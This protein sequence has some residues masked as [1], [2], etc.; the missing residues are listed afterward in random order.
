MLPCSRMHV[1]LPGWIVFAVACAG[2][3]V[4]RADDEADLQAAVAEGIACHERADYPAATKAY[5][6]ALALAPKVYGAEHEETALI[7]NNLGILY[8]SLGRY[9]QAEALYQKGLAIR[10]AK[11]GPDHLDVA[12]SLNN[13][14]SLYC[15]T[16]RYTEA[17]TVGQRSL[18]IR[19]SQLEADDPLLA[20]SLVN[21]ASVYTNLYENDKAET[22][23]LRGLKISEAKLGPDHPDVASN[24]N[25]LAALY[26]NL[27]RF[28]EAEPL[29]LRSLKIRETK[30]GA[31][32][33]EVAGSLNNLGG[34]YLA[35]GQYAKAQPL[36]RRGLEISVAR[37]G[38]QHPN[39][40]MMMN[41][42][43]VLWKEMGE[44]AKAEPVY[45]A[46]L[47]MREFSLGRNHPDVATTLSNLA[48]LYTHMDQYA[49]AEPLMLR[50]LE[51]RESKLGADHPDVAASLNNLATLYFEMREYSKA[52]APYRRSFEILKSKLGAEHPL[53]AFSLNSVALLH[54]AQ[55]QW[56]QAAGEIERERRIIRRHI[57]RT[58]PA[59]SEREQLA[60]LQTQNERAFFMA[61]SLG[62]QRREDHAIARASAGWVLNGKAVAQEVLAQRALAAADAKDPDTADLAQRAAS[63]R[64]RLAALGMSLPKSGQEAAYRQQLQSLSREEAELSRQLGAATGRKTANRSWVELDTLRKALAKDAILIEM[65][66]F[67]LAG[68]HDGRWQPAHY[69]AWVIPAEGNGEVA[70]VDLGEAKTIDA[71]VQRTRKALEAADENIRRDGES[72]AEEQ[73]R[74]TLRKL[75][76]LVLDPLDEHLGPARQWIL[77]PDAALWLIPWAA[78]PRSDGQYALE[79]HTIR[80]LV[81]GR[82][83]VEAAPAKESSLTAP[84]IFANPDYDLGTEQAAAAYHAV[85]RD[86]T[87]ARPTVV[88][89]GARSQGSLPRVA[90]LPGTADEAKAI[91]NSLARYASMETVVYEDQYALEGVF[92]SL[93]RPRALVLSTHG[94]FLPDQQVQSREDRL[95]KVAG[96]GDGKEAPVLTSEGRPLE[97]PLLRCGLLLTG[98][99][100]RTADESPSGDDGVLT[101]MEIVGTDL[102]DT[103]LVVLSACDTGLGQVHNGEG[104]AG[105]RQAFGLAGARSVVS[106][107]WQIP[108]QETVQLMDAFFANLAGGQPK[109]EAL[110]NAQL[111]QIRNLRDSRSAAHPYYWAAFTL[112]G[113]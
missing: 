94:F 15:A 55:E 39:V 34:L 96:D 89:R 27:G 56:S 30:L 108:D 51:I 71:A 12:D 69:A 85:F 33:P 32:H 54:A 10:E 7:T 3:G 88:S 46:A 68:F 22:L 113:E 45:Q 106:T 43:A 19:E 58:L 24:L 11:F 16:G 57:T 84:A 102:R 104:V 64:N 52:E 14:I 73:L 79:K 107:L 20:Q 50:S 29:F 81:S 98:C 42:L 5:E 82:D 70:I 31:D 90:R 21:L 40:A 23:F 44:Y 95:A 48:A 103:D 86:E 49:K 76:R 87:P 26:K 13:L 110:R 41:N 75:S 47:A 111:S 109:A 100:Q 72:A 8:E 61:L 92:K 59:L 60:F 105:L 99:N 18:R 67:T 62:L 4:G 83:L 36:F 101:G 35:M 93:H 65:A 1:L 38:P 2:P 63:V 28:A 74:N 25:N 97:N 112:T 9:A 17:E 78:L 53:V 91:K 6:R 37:L 66:R 77:S 80:Y